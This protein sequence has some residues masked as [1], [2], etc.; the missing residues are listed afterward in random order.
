MGIDKDR[1]L[2]DVDLPDKLSDLVEKAVLN[3][4]GLDRD[5][6]YPLHQVVHHSGYKSRPWYSKNLCGVNLVGALLAGSLEISP[7]VSCSLGDFPESDKLRALDF[8]QLGL[9][10]RALDV[11]GVR[12]PDLSAEQFVAVHWIEVEVHGGPLEPMMMWV[13]WDQLSNSIACFRESIARLRAV[14]L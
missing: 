7:E 10:R 13:G 9:M 12:L 2:V 8:V 6:Y 14:G 1:Y 11:L 4:E 3:Y 5:I